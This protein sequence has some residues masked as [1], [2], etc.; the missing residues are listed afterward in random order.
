MDIQLLDLNQIICQKQENLLL[1]MFYM[2]LKIRYI[3]WF[4]H[5]R[6][7][8]NNI[9]NTANIKFRINPCNFAWDRCQDQ[10]R[11][12]ISIIPAGPAPM[13]AHS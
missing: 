2:K 1:G 5:F 13:I 9:Y 12:P 4:L 3:L 11:R 7:L 10:R 6:A 8:W